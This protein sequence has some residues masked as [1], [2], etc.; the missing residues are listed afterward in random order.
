MILQ[1]LPMFLQWAW[2]LQALQRQVQPPVRLVSGIRMSYLLRG[3]PPH[4]GSMDND[5]QK[6]TRVPML[7]RALAFVAA[8]TLPSGVHVA[9]RLLMP[10]MKLTIWNS[11]LGAEMSGILV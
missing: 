11:G 5:T 3:G 1:P 2:L 10:L 7:T 6:Q 9:G 4:V 8:Q